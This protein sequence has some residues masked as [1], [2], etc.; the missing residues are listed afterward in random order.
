MAKLLKAIDSS[1]TTLMISDDSSLPRENGV[2]TVETEILSYTTNY[3]GTLYGCVRGIQDST[4]ASHAVGVSLILTDYYD[5]NV[6][7][8]QTI[9]NGTITQSQTYSSSGSNQGI[10]SDETL[11]TEAGRDKG[12]GG[13]FQASIMGNIHA[14]TL[15]ETGNYV[16][17]VI[18]A[19]SVASTN[20]SEL[21]S[22][23]VIGDI[24]D[25]SNS[26]NGIFTAVIDGNDPSGVTRA[27]AAFKARSLNAHASSGVDYG[28]DLFDTAVSGYLSVPTLPLAVAKADLRLTFSVCILNGA[29]VPTDGTTGATFAEIG[30]LYIDRTNGK[31][32]INGGTKTTPTWKIVTSA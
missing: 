29:G 25:P 23:A 31:L 10:A 12:E 32:Y 22:G 7:N 19:Y 20:A 6:S 2:L 30:S 1:E 11:T 24:Q 8:S 17:G 9:T 21:P 28:V 13:S 4:S 27:G 5:L 18:G 26:A 14:N 15:A 3:N 16:A